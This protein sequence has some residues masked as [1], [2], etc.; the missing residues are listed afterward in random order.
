[1]KRNSKK[2]LPIDELINRLQEAKSRGGKT[3]EFNGTILV[4]EN[5]NTVILTT[6]PQH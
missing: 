5:G 1:M 2:V 4:P 6:E 3:V